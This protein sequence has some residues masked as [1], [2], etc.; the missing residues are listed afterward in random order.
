LRRCND[1]STQDSL[2]IADTQS[3]FPTS[4]PLRKRTPAKFGCL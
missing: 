2:D 1:Y 3:G 4:Y